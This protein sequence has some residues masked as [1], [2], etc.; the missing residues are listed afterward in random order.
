MIQ[1]NLSTLKKPID[2]ANV[3]GYD[4]SKINVKMVLV[5]IALLYIPDFFVVDGFEQERVAAEESLSQLVQ[6]KNQLQ[7]KVSALKEF[8]KQ[9]QQLKRREAQL[10][11][12]LNV[13]KTIITKKK[14]P[15]NILVYVAKNIPP[16]IWLTEINYSADKLVFKGLSTDYTNQGLFLENLKKSIFFDK[17][18]SYS[19]TDTSTLPEELKNLAPFEITATITRF[20]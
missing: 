20:E 18:I 3:G 13:V 4:L 19:K 9:V 16:E 10:T 14:N 2:L 8:D 6:K 17:N 5:A 12:K 11:E 7:K 15:W 1:V